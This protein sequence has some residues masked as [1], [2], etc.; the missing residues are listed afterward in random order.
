[1]GE[2]NS[3]GKCT[4]D[5]GDCGSGTR[6]RT[7]EIETECQFGGDCSCKIEQEQEKCHE[8][9]QGIDCKM[10]EW[11]SWERCKFDKGDCGNGTKIRT[12]DIETKCQSGG[13]CSCKTEHGQDNCYEECRKLHIININTFHFGK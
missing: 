3:W 10:G 9:C 2:W 1:M 4:F 7:N 8:N 5:K 11:N 13:D 12:K 6:I